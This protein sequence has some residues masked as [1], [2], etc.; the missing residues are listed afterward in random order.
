MVVQ[1]LS[2]KCKSLTIILAQDADF[3]AKLWVRKHD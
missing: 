3:G 2:I 1:R